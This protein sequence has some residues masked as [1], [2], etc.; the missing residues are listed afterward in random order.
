MLEGDTGLSSIPE[1]FT[2]Q[3]RRQFT[4][5]LLVGTLD[6]CDDGVRD[7]YRSGD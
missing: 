1:D 2:V 7:I 6:V 5:S 4:V 3:L